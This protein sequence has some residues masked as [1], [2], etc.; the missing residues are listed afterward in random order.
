[1]REPD[2]VFEGLFDM[3]S[4]A[5]VNLKNELILAIKRKLAPQVVK[6]RAD[7]E[8]TCFSYEGIVGIKESLKAG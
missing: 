8:L 2:T 1:M 5:D 6:I 4:P 7:I 3:N